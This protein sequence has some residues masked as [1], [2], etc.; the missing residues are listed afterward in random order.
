MHNLCSFYHYYFSSCVVSPVGSIARVV[1]TNHYMV[2]P[3]SERLELKHVVVH[4]RNEF[5]WMQQM[6]K[7]SV[8]AVRILT[9]LHLL[10]QHIC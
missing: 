9:R 4:F 10:K 3:Q 8:C 2:P 7:Y 5:V 1:S 6:V